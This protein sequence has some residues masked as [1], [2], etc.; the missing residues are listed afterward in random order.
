MGLQADKAAV[1][2]REELG[3]IRN[4][5]IRQFVLDVFDA[6]G[7][8]WFWDRPCSLTGKYHPQISQGKG[9]LIRHVKYACYWGWRLCRALL[10]NGKKDDP[11]EHS[12]III[13]ALILHDLM[14]DGDPQLASKQERMGHGGK[15]LITGCHGVDLANAVWNRM[16]GQKGT[17][18][19][20]LILYGIAGHMGVWTLPEQ[21]RP[22]NVKGDLAQKVAQ[23]VHLADYCAAQQ[24]DEWLLKVVKQIPA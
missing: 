2:F 12:D 7:H 21:Y 23:I 8:D 10:G 11:G 13:A 9:G 16:L 24:A 4:P 17:P 19:Q 5:V 22:Y 14:K 18:D 15:S 6:F 3:W 1:V 20:I